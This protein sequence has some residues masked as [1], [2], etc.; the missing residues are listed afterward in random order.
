MQDADD[1]NSVF[2]WQ[3]E[4]EVPADAKAPHVWHEFWP[5]TPQAR[6]FRQSL[7]MATD[8]FGE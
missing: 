5:R 8:E 2:A 4:D 3:I 1:F 6:P 7:E